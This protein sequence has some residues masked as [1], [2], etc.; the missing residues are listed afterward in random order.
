MKNTVQDFIIWSASLTDEFCTAKDLKFM[1]NLIAIFL[2][3]L[4]KKVD[5]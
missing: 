3:E 1:G 4:G 5:E 2:E